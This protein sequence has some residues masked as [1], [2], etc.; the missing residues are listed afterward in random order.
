MYNHWS[1][2]PAL[3]QYGL[4]AQLGE[5]TVRIRKVEGSIPFESTTKE[6]SLVYQ[7]KRGFFRFLLLYITIYATITSKEG[8]NMHHDD[9]I[10]PF[11]AMDLCDGALVPIVND[12][13]D[14]LEIRWDDGMW[15]DVGFIRDEETYY[16]TTVADDTL[17]SWNNPL[18][19]LKTQNRTELIE[20]I[21]HEIF[22]CRL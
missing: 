7:G 11:L 10:A 22:R 1:R 20:I 4:V 3:L 16:I 15:I 6:T 14:M 2:A 13:E 9:W 12:D 5:R 21:Q 18:S 8:V 19:V 17:E